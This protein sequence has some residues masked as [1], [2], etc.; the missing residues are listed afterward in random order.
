MSFTV[1][2]ILNCGGYSIF[3]S[4]L[5]LQKR[6]VALSSSLRARFMSPEGKSV[7]EAAT[8]D[9]CITI[10]RED[11]LCSAVRH[12]GPLVFLLYV[13][14]NADMLGKL[15]NTVSHFRHLRVTITLFCLSGRIPISDLLQRGYRIEFKSRGNKEDGSD[16][17]GLRR[18][19]LALIAKE[20]FSEV[21]IISALQ[22]QYGRI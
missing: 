20:I 5:P 13:A 15:G 10:D 19:A 9:L 1:K 11:V 12:L 7:Y 22:F 6:L 2:G 8:A 16:Y 4:S 3:R 14:D 21:A 17:G 18:A